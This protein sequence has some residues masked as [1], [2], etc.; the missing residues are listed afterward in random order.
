M[1]A[2]I[3]RIVGKG[4]VIFKIDKPLPGLWYVE[5]ETAPRAHTRYTVGGFVDSPLKLILPAIPKVIPVNSPLPIAAQVVCGKDLVTG[6]RVRTRIIAPSIGVNKLMRK[7][8]RQLDVIRPDQDRVKDVPLDIVKLSILR[9]QLLKE[10]GKDILTHAV[11]N[12]P[13]AERSIHALNRMGLA[14]LIADPG[15]RPTTT[16]SW[17]DAL[18]PTILSFGSGIATGL[19]KKASESGTYNVMVKATGFAP[20]CRSRFTRLQMASV[21]VRG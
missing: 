16:G 5:V 20:T 12:I 9:A 4:Y 1:P 11:V 17:S 19:L 3:F 10:T 2:H 18:S 6:F 15:V 7:Y 13:M 21:L 14:H 8:A